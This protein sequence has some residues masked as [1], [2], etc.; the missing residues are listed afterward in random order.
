MSRLRLISGLILV[1][2]ALP[3]DAGDLVLP[4]FAHGVK[5]LNNGVWSS[6]IY[7]TN[8]GDQPVQVTLVH[9][10]PGDIVKPTPCD[11][12]MPPTRVVPAKSA[13]VWTAAG[14]ATDLGC[15]EEARG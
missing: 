15:A 9:F 13:V 12:F 14:L 5:G 10:L 1:L 11:L 6:E 2:A 4:V 3:A 7:L 8:P